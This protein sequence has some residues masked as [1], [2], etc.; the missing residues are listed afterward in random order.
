MHCSLKDL[1]IVFDDAGIVTRET[2]F[3]EL[4]ASHELLPANL[5]LGPLFAGLPEG[6]CQCA[7]WGYLLRGRVRVE[8]ADHE[9]VIEAGECFYMPPGHLP[10]FEEESEWVVFSPRGAHAVTAD[11]VRRNWAAMKAD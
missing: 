7:H 6:R 2:A 5:D 10:R 9:E 1:P 11:V 4:D 3:G 8:Y